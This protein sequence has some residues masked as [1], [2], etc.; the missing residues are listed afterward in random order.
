MR[1]L[2]NAP[3]ERRQVSERPC[4]RGVNSRVNKDVDHASFT[5]RRT[6]VHTTV[7]GPSGHL[8]TLGRRVLQLTETTGQPGIALIGPASTHISCIS[9]PMWCMSLSLSLDAK[10]T[11]GSGEHRDGAGVDTCSI[12]K[13]LY[14]RIAYVSPML[15]FSPHDFPPMFPNPTEEEPQGIRKVCSKRPEGMHGMVP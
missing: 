15:M 12:P 6:A 11:L 3:A 1:E 8:P 7:A 2:E 5:R 13:R 14:P 10:A 9:P 4:D